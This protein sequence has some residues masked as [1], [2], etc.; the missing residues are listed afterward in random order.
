MRNSHRHD[1]QKTARQYWEI[2]HFGKGVKGRS[3][4]LDFRSENGDDLHV[5]EEEG[6]LQGKKTLARQLRNS[7]TQ[8]TGPSPK[9]S[10]LPYLIKL[11]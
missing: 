10:Y 2:G 5:V 7:G 6:S 9:P 1:I 8:L 4:V 11:G 3:R